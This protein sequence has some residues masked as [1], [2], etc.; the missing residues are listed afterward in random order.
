MSTRIRKESD[1]TVLIKKFLS[2]MAKEEHEDSFCMK[3]GNFAH[4]E[5]PKNKIDF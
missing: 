4:R 1:Q 3:D 5:G 2:V